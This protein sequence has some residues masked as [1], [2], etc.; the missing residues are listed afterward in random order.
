M[1]QPVNN[2][3]PMPNQQVNGNVGQPMNNAGQPMNNGQMP[4]GQPQRMPNSQPTNG[5]NQ[6]MNNGQPQPA[7][8]MPNIP[9]RPP[10]M[11]NN[12]AQQPKKKDKVWP[13]VLAIIIVA[14]LIVGIGVG[15]FVMLAKKATDLASNDNPPITPAT[16]VTTEAEEEDKNSGSEDESTEEATAE[17]TSSQ[18]A[19]VSEGKTPEV[20][21]GSL[22]YFT[23]DWITDLGGGIFV[24]QA[25]N[26]NTDIIGHSYGITFTADCTE[27]MILDTTTVQFFYLNADLAMIEFA[28]GATCCDIAH[29][30]GHLFYVMPTNDD[31]T[32]GDLYLF[33]TKTGASELV[34]KKV[35]ANS[36]CISPDGKT[37]S[38]AKNNSKG[39]AVYVAGYNLKTTRVTDEIAVPYTVSNDAKIVYY[40]DSESEGLYRYERAT[41]T[42]TLICEGEIKHHYTNKYCTEI[43]A[44]TDNGTYFCSDTFENPLTV[45]EG[46]F[47]S[48]FT[49]YMI[50]DYSQF[51]GLLLDVEDMSDVLIASTNGNAYILNKL[52]DDFIDL[53]RSLVQVDT[54]LLC[55]TEG[56]SFIYAADGKVFRA[57]S[58]GDSSF[59]ETVLVDDVYVR[60]VLGNYNGEE[61]WYVTTDGDLYYMPMGGTGELIEKGIDEY[62]SDDSHNFAWSVDTGYMYY[63]KDG[64]LFQC[65]NSSATIEQVMT[66]VFDLT[67]SQSKVVFLNQDLTAIYVIYSDGVKKIF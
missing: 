19:Q 44:V 1:N 40:W 66:D 31:H 62:S 37:V 32:E 58:D 11:P 23:G 53:P 18:T 3:Q 63:T 54:I 28:P 48:I 17:D 39:Y 61:I 20:Y 42:K 56:T 67:Y 65:Y 38:Y 46:E 14:L 45:F 13:T 51:G 49:D 59:T 7:Q 16:H 12:M 55:D 34:D 47:H 50:N 5:M 8:G 36:P 25:G 35:V 10:Y 9:N 6:P 22:N 52:G 41:K 60:E 15:A 4:N 43:I 30:G 26:V 57:D 24:N 33:D 64:V 29:D 27:A 21:T 2:G